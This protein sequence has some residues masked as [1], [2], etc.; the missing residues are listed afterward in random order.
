VTHI[1]R[2][3]RDCYAQA[4]PHLGSIVGPAARVI[5]CGYFAGAYL[6][7]VL[8]ALERPTAGIVLTA[9]PDMRQFERLLDKGLT[10]Q[11][12]LITHCAHQARWPLE[13]S[14][15]GRTLLVM[16]S[17]G[18]GLLPRE[19]AF[20]VLE[21]A[22]N[23]LRVGDLALIT[24]EQPRDGALVEASYED[25]GKQIVL[26]ALAQIGRHEG[27]MPRIFYEQSAHAVRLGAVAE[28]PASIVWN[29]TRC[30]L[31]A[32]TWLDM[33]AIHMTPAQSGLQLHPDFEIEDR[34]TSG[35][36]L[37]SLLLLRK[38]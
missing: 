19:Q 25:F 24:L 38:I 5:D 12:S 23:A 34:W 1:E 27:L 30:Q 32:G 33:G 4:L 13:T 26:N 11:I 28:G 37:V 22:S 35:D 10:A 21:N 9:T 18:F 36:Q 8:S 17:G 3:E 20:D 29:G 7:Q 16:S 14:A 6:T 15:A 31:P 2:G